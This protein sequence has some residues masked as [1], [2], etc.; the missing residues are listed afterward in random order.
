[1]VNVFVV[2]LV[3]WFQNNIYLDDFVIVKMDIFEDEE[4]VLMMKLVYI[5]VVEWIDKYYIIFFENQY[6]KLQI[7]FEVYGFQI[8][9]WDEVNEIFSDFNDVNLVKVLF[10]VGFVK[11]DCRFLN[12]LDMFVLFLYVKDL[13]VKF[14]CVLKMLVV[15]NSYIEERLDVGVFL[16]YDLIVMYGDLV[17]DFFLK[18]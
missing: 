15:Y 8:F 3:V 12:F 14:L 13:L 17:E 10:G 4:E 11:R 2:D 18:F 1:M 6:Y 9:G 16:L 5:E 7:I